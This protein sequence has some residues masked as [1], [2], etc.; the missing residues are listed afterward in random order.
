MK[1]IIGKAVAQGVDPRVV[2]CCDRHILRCEEELN[3]GELSTL[4]LLLCF[5]WLLSLQVAS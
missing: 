5:R 4:L 1:V 2:C 3:C